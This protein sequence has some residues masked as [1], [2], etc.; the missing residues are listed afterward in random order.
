MSKM[1]QP[2]HRRTRRDVRVE[3]V[4]RSGLFGR[5]ALL[6]VVPLR[7]RR[8][9]SAALSLLVHPGSD[10]RTGTDACSATRATAP[11]GCWACADP[12]DGKRRRECRSRLRSRTV[13]PCLG[14]FAIQFR[15]VERS[16]FQTC[17][18]PFAG[19]CARFRARGDDKI[20]GGRRFASDRK[21]LARAVPSSGLMTREPGSIAESPGLLRVVPDRVAGRR[22]RRGS[23]FPA[24]RRPARGS[25]R[26][27]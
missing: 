6:Q 4:A 2:S 15:V 9:L 26:R 7:T 12:G 20:P 18:C 25:P 5:D 10:P 22:A 24:S 16:R 27:T 21:G 3:L 8:G 17:C 14:R 19:S 1:T 23:G 13:E 11:R